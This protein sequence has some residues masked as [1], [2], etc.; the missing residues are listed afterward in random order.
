MEL[1]EFNLTGVRYGEAK[2][3]RIVLDLHISGNPNQPFGFVVA[4]VL[5]LGFGGF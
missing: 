1:D 5:V 4:L 3:M 2:G